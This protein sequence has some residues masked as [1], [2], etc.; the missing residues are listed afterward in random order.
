MTVPSAGSTVQK[1]DKLTFACQTNPIDDG[2]FVRLYLDDNL[3]GW[4]K[5]N[6]SKIEWVAEKIKPG[7]HQIRAEVTFSNG[8]MINSQPIKFILND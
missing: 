2:A 7:E 4:Q 6:L 1:E 3:V 5:G 8:I